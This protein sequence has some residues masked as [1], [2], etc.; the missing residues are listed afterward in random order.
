MKCLSDKMQI[1]PDEMQAA[2]GKAEH[3]FCAD[4]EPSALR[5]TCDRTSS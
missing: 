4:A 5:Y 2:F 3:F 1:L